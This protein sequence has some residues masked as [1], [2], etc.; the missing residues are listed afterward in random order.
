M[1]GVVWGVR[2]SYGNLQLT[3]AKLG[4]MWGE[5]HFNLFCDM[6]VI[7]CIHQPDGISVGN[8]LLWIGSG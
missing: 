5:G 3:L 4:H 1:M 6:L 8:P 2:S 7:Y